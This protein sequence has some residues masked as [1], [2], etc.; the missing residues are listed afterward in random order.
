[1]TWRV[2]WPRILAT[3]KIGTLAATMRPAAVCR[4]V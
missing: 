1:V 3:S 4:S 2:E